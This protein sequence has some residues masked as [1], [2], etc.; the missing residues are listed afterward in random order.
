MNAQRSC[1]LTHINL[2]LSWAQGHREFGISHNKHDTAVTAT[3]S[4]ISAEAPQRG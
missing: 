4:C 3:A 1:G 2:S